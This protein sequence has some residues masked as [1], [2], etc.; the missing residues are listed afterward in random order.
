MIMSNSPS[1]GI[2]SVSSYKETLQHLGDLQRTK[3][4]TIGAIGN[5]LEGAGRTVFKGQLVKGPLQIGQGI[6][7]GLDAPI[8]L[9]ADTNRFVFG[10]KGDGVP[11][12]TSEYNY[13]VSRAI[14]SASQVKDPLGAIGAAGDII[15]AVGFKLGSDALKAFR[16]N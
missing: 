5:I 10:P 14:G 13:N 15:H 7:D 11:T 4:S 9:A 6:L 1:S 8:S 12:G 2:E 16:N 3:E